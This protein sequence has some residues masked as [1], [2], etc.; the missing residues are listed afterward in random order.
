[1][2]DPLQTLIDKDAI[3]DL[4]LLYSRGVDRQD[5]ELLR[6][7]YTP[8]GWD[9]HGPHFDGPADK[10]VDFLAASLPHLRISAHHICNHLISVDGDTG[11]GEVYCIAWHV[12][13]DGQGGQKHHT[14][15]VRYVDQYVRIDTRWY[16]KRRDV[17][18]DAKLDLPADDHGLA[19]D[20]A[21]DVSF[22]ALTHRLFARGARE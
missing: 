5:F 17:V 7:L 3:R 6:T 4:A 22:T 13:P 21:L 11:N 2:T 14:Q 19:P 18:F 20:R 8:D 16:F 9:S 1:M 12:I 15:F 10:Y